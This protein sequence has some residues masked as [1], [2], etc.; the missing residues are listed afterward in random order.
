MRVIVRNKFR[1]DAV[2]LTM[3]ESASHLECAPRKRKNDDKPLAAPS[4]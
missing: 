2:T 3:W 4:K 1:A